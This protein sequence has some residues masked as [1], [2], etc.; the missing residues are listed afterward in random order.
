M[1]QPVKVAGKEKQ[2]SM[3]NKG[4]HT[5]TSEP[6]L[7]SSTETVALFTVPEYEYTGAAVA[8]AI[9]DSAS[10]IKF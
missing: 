3:L 2:P 1:Q 9:P 10:E 5:Y 6:V 8:N 4:I 7:A